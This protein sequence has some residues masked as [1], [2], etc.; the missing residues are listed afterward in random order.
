VPSPRCFISYSW[1]SNQH[2]DWVRI[3]GEKLRENGVDVILDQW[4]LRPGA[5]I[6]EFVEQS[7]VGSDY[8]LLVCTPEFAVKSDSLRGG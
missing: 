8:T 7:I 3:L 6:T 1:D 2:K 5:D 4:H